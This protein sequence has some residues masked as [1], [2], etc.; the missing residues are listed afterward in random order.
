MPFTGFSVNRRFINDII[1]F[2]RTRW[3]SMLTTFFDDFI[4]FCTTRCT[5]VSLDAIC[6][7]GCLRS[8]NTGIPPVADRFRIRTILAYFPMTFIINTLI[9]TIIMIA[10]SDKAILFQSLLLIRTYKN[11]RIIALFSLDESFPLSIIS[12]HIFEYRIKC[13]IAFYKQPERFF[14]DFCSICTFPTV[15]GLARELTFIEMNRQDGISRCCFVK[16]IFPV[17]ISDR[18]TICYNCIFGRSSSV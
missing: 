5:C 6:Q 2:L 10:V 17:C 7:M 1:R 18:S 14:W 11:R 12:C 9:T 13:R 16:R 3:V 4:F 15:K 8:N